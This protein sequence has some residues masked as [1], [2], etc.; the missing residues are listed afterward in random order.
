L[1]PDHCVKI[2]EAYWNHW[3]VTMLASLR[4]QGFVL[5]V[6]HDGSK[7][8]LEP[9][10]QAALAIFLLAQTWAEWASHRLLAITP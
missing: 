1:T 9:F 6:A 10:A 4:D 2:G 8:D 7:T 5:C 3:L